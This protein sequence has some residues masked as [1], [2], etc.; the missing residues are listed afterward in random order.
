MLGTVEKEEKCNGV[1]E[2]EGANSH[3]ASLSR[4]TEYL[5]VTRS[6]TQVGRTFQAEGTGGPKP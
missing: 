3:G 6:I 5:E 4:D 2:S 1:G